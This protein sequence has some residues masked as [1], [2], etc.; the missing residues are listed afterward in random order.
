MPMGQSDGC[1]S[2]VWYQPRCAMVKTRPAQRNTEGGS[3]SRSAPAPPP[4]EGLCVTVFTTHMRNAMPIGGS[5]GCLITVWYQ[6][7]CAMVKSRLGRRYADVISIRRSRRSRGRT[8]GRVT[9]RRTDTTYDTRSS[10]RRLPEHHMVPAEECDGQDPTESTSCGR[11]IDTTLPP[12][13]GSDTL[14]VTILTLLTRYTIPVRQSGGC[15]RTT[16]YQPRCAMVK[17][18]LGRR[19]A[20]AISIQRSRRPPD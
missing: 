19:H 12:P 11:D 14:R 16:W 17:S 4:P 9:V 8:S 6:L 10:I 18:R 13:P 1:L 5:D 20:D 7:R 15:L 3:I 2:T